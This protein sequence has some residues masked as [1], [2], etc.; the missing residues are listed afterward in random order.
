MIRI[1]L[2][3]RQN[4]VAQAIQQ[5]FVVDEITKILCMGAGIVR[6]SFN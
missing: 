4:Q 6:T 1:E 5:D 3:R 2:R